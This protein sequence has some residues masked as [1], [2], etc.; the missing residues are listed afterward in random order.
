[1]VVFVVFSLWVRCRTMFSTITTAPSTTM[2]KSS[3]PRD[4]RFAGIFLRLRQIEANKKDAF[5]EIT[6]DRMRGVMNQVAAIQERHDFHAR[7]EDMLVKLFDL[8]V[9]SCQGIV[10]IR[11]FAE[12]YDSFHDIVVIDD[13]AI[14][15]MN[16]FS[17][18]TEPDL[19][20]LRHRRNVPHSKRRAVLRHDYGLLDIQH[21]GE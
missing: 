21:V 11:P 16:C 17:N 12:E 8:R 5:G 19:G 7:R 10:G 14:Q 9:Y 20:T 4:R 15:A 6:Q 1:M 13:G 3:A 18:L 2:P